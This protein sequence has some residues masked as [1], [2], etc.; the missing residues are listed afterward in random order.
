MIRLSTSSQLTLLGLLPT[1]TI[2][3]SNPYPILTSSFT[4][5]Q[6]CGP[7]VA[8]GP[9]AAGVYG[10][11]YA[12]ANNV[13]YADNQPIIN[14]V[15][16]GCG[17]CWH[18]QPQID[19]FPINKLKIGTSVVVK[20][21]DQCTDPGYCD[22]TET[23]D[24]NTRYGKQVHFDLCNATGVTNQFFGQIAAGVV[25]GLAQRLPDCSALDDG[26]FGS[27]LGTLGG[28]VLDGEGGGAPK[29]SFILPSKL[30]SEIVPPTAAPIV[31]DAFKIAGPASAVSSGGIPTS[32]AASGNGAG[33]LT[34]EYVVDE[35]NE[36]DAC[37]EL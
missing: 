15:G 12:A 9:S 33:V 30:A 35:G 7:T 17:Q 14:G 31:S 29:V 10:T 2:A 26:P 37:E 4:W 23:S 22:Q 3:Q 11:G 16:A 36:D 27:D 1:L 32:S 19:E 13:T 34:N 5:N 8:C 25:M 6:I 24:V 28:G 18:L 20:I 21:N